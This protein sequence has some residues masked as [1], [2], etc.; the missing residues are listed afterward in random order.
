MSALKYA[1]IRYT[2]KG[3]TTSYTEKKFSNTEWKSGDVKPVLMSKVPNHLQYPFF[4]LAEGVLAYR[5]M[6]DSLDAVKSLKKPARK[7]KKKEEP[8]D[9][10]LEE[11][12]EEG[13]NGESEDEEVDETGYPPDEE[14]EE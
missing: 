9:E 2:G 7:S 10:E 13:E 3:K 6:E 11:I 14:A 8:T 4:E 1:L 5:N 12:E